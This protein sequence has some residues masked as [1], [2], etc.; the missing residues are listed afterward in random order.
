ME[1]TPNTKRIAVLN[2]LCRTAMGVMGKVVQTHGISALPPEDQSKI[3]EMV[4]LYD[5]FTEANNPWGERDF[6]NF[7][8][9]GE[10]IYWKIDIFSDTTFTYGSEHP[11]DPA[12]SVRVLTIMLATEY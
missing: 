3:R 9:K 6:G 1:I 7:T 5:T 12:K 11:E 8:Y 10:S 4:E 2:D